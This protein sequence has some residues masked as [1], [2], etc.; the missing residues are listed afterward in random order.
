MTADA[1]TVVPI[2]KGWIALPD[3]QADAGAYTAAN[4]LGGLSDGAA[5]RPASARKLYSPVAAWA[6]M[7]N[8]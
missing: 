8:P 2:S 7:S 4:P 6:A 3:N 1:Q 5:R